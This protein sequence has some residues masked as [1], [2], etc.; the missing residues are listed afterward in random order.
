MWYIDNEDTS[1]NN[2]SETTDNED[3]SS[4]MNC[5]LRTGCLGDRRS[6]NNNSEIEET[7]LISPTTTETPTAPH[8]AGNALLIKPLYHRIMSIVLDNSV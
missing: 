1:T 4:C 2:N 7:P 8:T 6:T 3:T 5:V